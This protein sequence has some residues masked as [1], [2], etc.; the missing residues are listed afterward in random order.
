MGNLTEDYSLGDSWKLC[1][2]WNLTENYSLGDSLS[3]SS[4]ELF[5]RGKGGARIYRD[6]PGGTHG[7]EPTSQCRTH[8]RCRFSP[9]VGKIPLEQEM[10]AHS[11]ILA[12]RI[13]IDRGAWC[14]TV[15]RVTKSWIQL[16][17]LSTQ[18]IQE[19]KKQNKITTKNM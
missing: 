11:R 15:H 6:F 3:E 13:P 4:A 19:N 10:V 18:D 12:W 2:V 17:Q 1:F 16:K 14:G 5:Q 9:W 7:K 8:K